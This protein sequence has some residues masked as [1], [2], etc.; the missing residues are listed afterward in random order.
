[1]LKK[2]IVES[3]TCFRVCRGRRIRRPKNVEPGEGERTDDGYEILDE[4]A[5]R[6]KP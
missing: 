1:M 2:I 4:K 3:Y 6:K 5:E